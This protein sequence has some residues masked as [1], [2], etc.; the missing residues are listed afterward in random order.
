MLTPDDR[1]VLFKKASK[2]AKDRAPVDINQV[3]VKTLSNIIAAAVTEAIVEY[4]RI[5]Q[6]SQ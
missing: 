5:T 1:Q 3:D 2:A 4:D 6:A